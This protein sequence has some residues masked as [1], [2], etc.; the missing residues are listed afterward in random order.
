MMKEHHPVLEFTSG[1][2]LCNTGVITVQ[3][4]ITLASVLFNNSGSFCLTCSVLC[5]TSLNITS[6]PSKN[7]H[8]VSSYLVLHQYYYSL[9]V[10][11]LQNLWQTN[12]FILALLFFKLYSQSVCETYEYW[13]TPLCPHSLFV[14]AVMF[15][16]LLC[17]SS[18][19][20]FLIWTLA[21]MFRNSL[22]ARRSMDCLVPPFRV[23]DRS[24]LVQ[25]WK[26]KG[27]IRKSLIRW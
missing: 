26:W 19:L 12:L 2:Q 16:R 5:V 27:G 20:L 10:I 15:I 13:I 3:F 23:R 25:V 7:T 17:W 6:L 11:H 4:I 14:F 21:A 8:H 18:N 9:Y 24:C 22:K 1:F